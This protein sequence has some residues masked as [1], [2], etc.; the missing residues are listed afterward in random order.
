MTRLITLVTA[1]AFAV[2]SAT[3]L[4]QGAGTSSDA[5]QAAPAAPAAKA[6]GTKKTKKKKTKTKQQTSKAQKPAVAPKGE[7]QAQSS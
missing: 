5:P 6:D 7:A 4:A 3:V 1:A 2:A